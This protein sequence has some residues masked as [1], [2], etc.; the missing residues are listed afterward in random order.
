MPLVS[1]TP[2][3][4]GPMPTHHDADEAPAGLPRLWQWLSLAAVGFAGVGSVMGFVA[5]DRIYGQETT[6]LADAAAAQD[7]VNLVL[8]VPLLV[9]LGRRATRGSLAAYLGWL[10]CLTFTVYNYAIYAFSVHFGP[11]FLVW[12][13]V[14]GLSSFALIGG[15]ATLNVAAVERRYAGRGAPL[16]A[17]LLIGVA[18]LFVGLWLSEIIPDLVAGAPSRS[19]SDWRV[20]TNPVHVLDLAFFLPAVAVIGVVFAAATTALARTLRG[21][22]TEASSATGRIR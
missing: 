3:H 12:V 18:A 19:A 1:G 5:G 8:V 9:V 21:L 2:I 22:G 13:A 4:P 17:W 16:T 7:S 10:G 15:L 11:L 14:L 20:P 6:S